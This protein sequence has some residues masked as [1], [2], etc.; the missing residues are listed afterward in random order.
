M[1]LFWFL[2]YRSVLSY[3][4]QFQL[5]V[6]TFDYFREAVMLPGG[7]SNYL[8]EALTQFYIMPITGA[9]IISLLLLLLQLIIH[10]IA[11]RLYGTIPTNSYLLSYVPLLLLWLYLG[12]VNVMLSYPIALI[13]LLCVAWAYTFICNKNHRLIAS[14]L[15]A[16][17]SYWLLGTVAYAFCLF[18]LL[19]E[20]KSKSGASHLVV[21]VATQ[22]VAIVAMVFFS[23]NIVN[24][25]IDRLLNGLFYYR[26]PTVVPIVQYLLMVVVVIVPFLYSVSIVKW[27]GFALKEIVAV[28]I[29]VFCSAT[30]IILGVRFFYDGRQYEL[31]DYDCLVRTNNW[32]GILQKATARQPELPMSVC[33]TNLALGM[34]DQLCE[35]AFQYYQNGEEGLLPPFRR[36]PNSL[37]I[38]AEAYYQLGLVNT[39]QR[40]YF[41]AMEAIPNCSKSGRCIRR[42]AETN[43]INGQYD[44]ALKYLRILEKTLF[45]KR[46]AQQTMQLMDD[47]TS[48]DNHPFYG[49]IR[50]SLLTNDLLFSEQEVDK[51]LGQLIIQN[52]DNKLAMQYMLIHPLLSRDIDKFMQYF[53]VLQKRKSFIPPIC[54]QGI[55]FACM[56]R[57]IPIPQNLVDNKE[58]EKLRRFATIMSTEGKESPKLNEYK[59]T[60]WYYLLVGNIK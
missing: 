44:V 50:R 7:L 39:A 19:F 10:A 52:P 48:I 2:P 26:I 5:F 34:T 27:V 54:Q 30:L 22:S 42:I 45:Y 46:W 36:E 16:M 60:L 40:F 53:A 20:M 56:Q 8:A 43:I 6:T 21:M 49:R 31:I 23:S 55:L 33:A 58:T 28:G 11:K 17:T 41:E 13:S 51:L 32:N 57:S 59:N 4:E 15:I 47:E 37:L 25:P 14:V 12:D 24:Y 38:T 3:H 1:F 29:F 9:L 35:K 18:A